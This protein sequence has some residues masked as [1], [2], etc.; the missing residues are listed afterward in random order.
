ML[1]DNQVRQIIK[2]PYSSHIVNSDTWKLILKIHVPPKIC[3]F[4]WRVCSNYLATNG[5]L[6]RRKI[7]ASYLCPVCEMEKE[8]VKH[9][10]LT[11]EWVQPFGLVLI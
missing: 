5:N 2:M 3:N 1:K 10:L 7:K 9:A 11:F 8:T 4:L 6:W